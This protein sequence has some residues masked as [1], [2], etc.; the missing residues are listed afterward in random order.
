MR[1][2]A[3][4]LDVPLPELREPHTFCMLHPWVN[5]GRVGSLV[6]SQFETYLK[7]K[8]LGRLA[9]AGN[10]FDFTRYRPTIYL[11]EGQRQ[12]IIPNTFITYAKP[13]TGNDFL[14]LHLL[15]PHM[16]GEVYVDSVLMLLE[17]FGTKRYCLLGSMYD[18]V[19]HTKPLIVTG[20]GVGKSAEQ[21]LRKIG[22]QPSDYEG[23]T[24]IVYLISQRATEMG[25][26]TMNLI[27][28]LPQYAQLDEDYAGEIRL[29]E[30]LHLLYDIPVA[31]ADIHKAEQQRK[32]IDTAAAKNPY[33]KDIIAQ[34]EAYYDIR[35]TGG[36][37]EEMPRLS[38]EVEGFLREMDKRFRE[39]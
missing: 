23:P 1:I 37:E 36:K 7:A 22:V 12:L 29:M 2:G 11:E 21:D 28:H 34:L 19:P 25:I 31:E 15:E 4:E 24:T 30:M 10:F 27:V 14:F 3:F 18:M 32:Q 17:R 26:E 9:K 5:V 38:P 8:G 16:L 13:R 39:R 35:S 20:G 33:L 6:L